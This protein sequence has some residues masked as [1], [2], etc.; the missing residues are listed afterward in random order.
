MLAAACAV[1][2][3]ARTSPLKYRSAVSQSPSGIAVDQA[4]QLALQLLG[5]RPVSLSMRGQ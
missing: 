5:V 4:V 2:S 3:L 1:L